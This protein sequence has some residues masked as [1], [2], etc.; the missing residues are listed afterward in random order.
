[1]KKSAI[2]ILLTVTLV[3]AAFVGG[4]YMGRNYRHADIQI[5]GSPS[6]THSA[7][8]GSSQSSSGSI[9]TGTTSPTAPSSTAS[10]FPINI[11]TATAEQLDQ[12]PDIGPV[13]AQR[14]IAYRNEFG[15]FSSIE[16]LLNV[17][18]IGEKTLAK[19]REYITV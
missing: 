6:S 10:A 8:S 16:D 19:I 5:S 7:P 3:F 18:G 9:P 14:I 17:N 2:W 1:M 12:L 11:N 15:P 13:L 4:F